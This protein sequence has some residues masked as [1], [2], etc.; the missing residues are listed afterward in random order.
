VEEKFQ[1]I[2][3]TE[4]QHREYVNPAAGI[5]SRQPKKPY[6]KT[7]KERATNMQF[8]N[9][10]QLSGRAMKRRRIMILPPSHRLKQWGRL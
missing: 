1:S 9:P 6:A 2:L 8:Q 5:K 3:K 4:Y 7:L 10:E